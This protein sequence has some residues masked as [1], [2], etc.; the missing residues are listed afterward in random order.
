M[1]D[2]APAAFLSVAALRAVLEVVH[3]LMGAPKPRSK[4]ISAMSN[5]VC[6]GTQIPDALATEIIDSVAVK[7]SGHGGEKAVFAVREEFVCE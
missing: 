3:C 1:F 2:R 7:R 5:A 4:L 6:N